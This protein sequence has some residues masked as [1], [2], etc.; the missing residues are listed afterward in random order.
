MKN[1]DLGLAYRCLRALAVP[2]RRHSR[3]LR[4]SLL[5]L[6]VAFLSGPS[7]LAHSPLMDGW[8]RDWCTGTFFDN[9]GA[10]VENS[11]VQL[12]CGRCSINNNV[13]CLVDA[14][15]KN[16][17][18]GASGPY[19]AADAG[20]CQ[21][22][23]NAKTGE[24]SWWDDRT[25]GAVNDLGTVVTTQ[26]NNNF[27]FAAELWV[28]PDPVSLPFAEI[29]IDFMP[30][31]IDT[32]H[33]PAG[34]LTNPGHCS[35]STDRACTSDADCNFCQISTEPFPSTRV[36]TCGSGCDPGIGDVCDTS[37]TCVDLGTLGSVANVGLN[38]SPDSL[39]DYLIIFDFGRWL[40]GAADA[41]LLM[42]DIG[43]VW[44]GIAVFLP[45]VNPGASGGSGGPPG[46][47][48]VAIPWSS[49]GCTG[50]PQ[51]CVCPDFG[52]GQ[53]FKF[54]IVIARGI[55]DLDYAPDG[56]IEDVMSESVAG[57][58]TTTPDSC[59]G[60]GIGTTGCEIADGSVDSFTP[61][62][63]PVPGGRISQLFVNKSAAGSINLAWSPSC[64]S[65][66]TDYEVYEGVLG[67]F[68]SHIP[69]PGLCTTAGVT[70]ATFDP[71]AEQISTTSS[72]R[73][74]APPRGRTAKTA[75]RSSGR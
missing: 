73:P 56:A 6:M 33:D 47:M 20:S 19:P 57:T 3:V 69:V 17:P 37:Q 13:A 62:A 38:A 72:S 31:G 29:G 64:S 9:P 48:E 53:D 70:T 75:Q 51:A 1:G 74:T 67:N 23:P 24:I 45:A 40:F 21:N 36:R 61:L 41:T 59:P 68:N 18:T 5:L 34:V 65:A 39:P 46:S 25:D 10:R 26:D 63:P 54:S 50:C 43:G 52:P 8:I 12:A 49:F 35:V 14:D 27:Y 30:G 66:D 2:G 4:T 71:G 44:T 22:V 16:L 55:G 15:C 7:V 42:K 11:V 60:F 28:D 32:W 58:S